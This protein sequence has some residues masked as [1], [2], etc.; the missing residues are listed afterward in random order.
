M[1][2]EGLVRSTRF[3]N[4]HNIPIKSLTTDGHKMIRKWMREDPTMK[5]TI[6]YL[7]VWHVAKGIFEIRTDSTCIQM[8]NVFRRSWDFVSCK[9]LHNKSSIE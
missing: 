9:R 7:D 2:K 6:Q 3:F 1:E 8:I 4:H 5:N